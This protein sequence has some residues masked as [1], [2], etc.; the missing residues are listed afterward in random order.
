MMSLATEFP[1]S[2]PVQEILV[3]VQ[4]CMARTP[5]PW[6]EAWQ[7]EYADTIREAIL[8]GRENSQYT[9]R[10]QIICDGFGP[11]WQSLTNSKER[12]A[13]EVRRAQIRWYIEHLMNS[14]LPGEEERH[15]LRQ[16]CEDLA[17]HGAQ[18]LLAQFSF[19]DPNMVH[20]AKA[21]CLADCHRNIDAPLLPIFLTPFSQGQISEIKER[22]HKLRYARVDL[23]RQLGGGRTTS[24]RSVHDTASP[25]TH[26]DYLLAQRSLSQ[27]RAQVWAVASPPP[28]Y[29][30]TAVANDVEAQ[31]R[32]FQMMSEARRQESRLGNAVLQTEYLSFLLGAL[33][34][35]AQQA[36][37]EQ[38]TSQDTPSQA[39]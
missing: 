17:E 22:W 3:V 32:K 6:P 34:E 24:P 5:T 18:S 31:K 9:E 38:T 2:D 27:L 28:D 29:Y 30:R 37:S 16:Q 25:E 33:L 7:R 36:F 21:D 8:S 14:A 13:F 19:L 4:D 12:S 15:V 1:Q 39:R 26:P 20:K 11:Y 35:T 10:L 23:W